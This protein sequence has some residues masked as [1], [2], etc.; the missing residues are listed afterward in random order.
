M[1]AHLCRHFSRSKLHRA[2]NLAA[3]EAPCTDV[4][5][6]GRAV[7][8]RFHALNVGLPRT[9][10]ASMGVAHLDTKSNTLITK[11][12]L[13]HLLHL[14]AYILA[15]KLNMFMAAEKRPYLTENNAMNALR[16]NSGYYFSRN[17]K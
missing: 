6:A 9:V 1:P 5:M 2:G 3:A 17:V 13:C 10:A 15:N 4:Y 16:M 8:N 12:T 11:F 14:L 7:N